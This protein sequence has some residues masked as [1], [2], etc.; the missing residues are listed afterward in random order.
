MAERSEAILRLFIWICCSIIAAFWE[1][2]A[3]AVSVVHLIYVLIF[4][5][6]HKGMA[7]FANNFISY[8][9]SVY[10]YLYFTTNERPWP[11]GKI[12]KVEKVE[13]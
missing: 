6:R 8:M 5:R 7:E 10:R 3:W 9:Y 11:F 1:V 2:I 13:I 4:G 12:K